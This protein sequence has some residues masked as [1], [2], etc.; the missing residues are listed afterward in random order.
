MNE[1]VVD[2]PSST[3]EHMHYVGLSRVRNISALHI[4]NLNE[5]KIEVSEK[6]TNEMN[7]LRKDANLIPLI[8]FKQKQYCSIMF[9]LFTCI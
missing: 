4:V 5:N 9:N 2:F 1:A 3:M 6:V 8:Y 7:R